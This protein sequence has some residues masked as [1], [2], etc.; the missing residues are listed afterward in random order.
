MACLGVI[1]FLC[2]YYFFTSMIADGGNRVVYI[3]EDDNIDSVYAKL[4]TIASHHAMSGFKT[5]VRHSSYEENIRTGRYEIEDGNSAFTVFRKLKNGLQSS[6]RLTIPS[7]R[8]A[9]RL[10]GA[11]AKNLWQTASAYTKRLPTRPLAPSMDTHP[12]RCCAC[13]FP[14][15]TKCIGTLL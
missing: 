4:D 12:K 15:H 8:T 13:S 14:T 9:D 11:L 7:V 5:L 1:L 2:Y 6:V 3:D 10:A